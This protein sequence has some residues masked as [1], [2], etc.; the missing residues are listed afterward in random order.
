[1][2]ELTAFQRDLVWVI[3]GMERPHGI[4]IKEALEEYYDREVHHGQLYPN[5]DTLV[6]TGYVE[7][8]EADGRTNSYCAT[9]HASKQVQARKDWEDST[10]PV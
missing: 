6:D 1:M 2:R 3:S 7:K 4:A 8:S 9:M 5:L 10:T